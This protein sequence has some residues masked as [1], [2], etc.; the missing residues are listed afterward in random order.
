MP[1]INRPFRVIVAFLVL[2]IIGIALIPRLSVNFTPTYVK[3]AIT[4]T[5]SLPNSSP[6]IVERLA[7][8]PLENALSQLEGTNKVTS[9]SKYNGGSIEISFDKGV[10]VDF[11]KFEV[12]TII[13]NIYRKLPENMSYPRI[14]QRGGENQ[15]E[16]ERAILSYSINGPY[17]SYKLQ[18]DVEEFVKKPLSQLRDLKQVDVTD[19]NSLQ[20]TID[21]DVPTLIRYNL[22]KAQIT[23]ALNSMNDAVYAG[24]AAMSNGQQYFLKT[25]GQI[26]DMQALESI[27]IAIIEGKAIALKDVARLYLEEQKPNS[28]RRI[29]GRNAVYLSIYAREGV[30]KVLLAAEVKETINQLEDGLPEGVEIILEN[31]DTEFLA[32]E[33]NKIYIRTGLSVLILVVFIFL[34]NRNPKYLFTLFLGIIVNLCLTV[35]IVYALKVELHM[36]SIAGVT[37]SFG[38][39]VD[40]AIVM[41]D[42]MHRKKNAKIF[43]ALLAASL[44]TIMALLLVLLLPEDERR[45]LTD[46]SIVVAINL[47]VS[48]LI[49]LFFTPSLYT[50]LF[51][52]RLSMGRI[53]TYHRLRRKVRWFK[54]YMKSIAFVVKYRKAF[55][56]IVVLGFGL[57]V[58][59]LPVQWEGQEWYNKTIGSD[60]YQDEI[61]PVTDK[62][63]GG[64]LRKFVNEVYAGFRYGSPQQ[65]RLNVSARLP[66]GTTLDDANFV[67]SKVEEYLVGI[68]G[69]DK[70]ITN[71]SR[72]YATTQITFTDAYETS[73]LPYQLKGRLQARSIDLT[74]VAWSIT[75]VG[76]GFSAG[77]ERGETPS[78]R[79]KMK[80][81]NFDELERQA[82][83]MADKL[84]E[85]IRVNEVNT[86]AQVSWRSQ[87]TSEYVLDFDIDRLATAGINRGDILRMLSDLTEPMPGNSS[88]AANYNNE[89]L[90]VYIKASNAEAFSKYDL[91]EQSLPLDTGRF[92]K[93]KDYASLSFERTANEI[94]KEDRQYLRALTYDYNG[95]FKFA[96]RHRDEKIKEMNAEIPVGYVV[97]TQDNYFSFQREKRQYGILLVLIVG[98]FFICSIL[99]ENLKQPFNIIV[100]IPISFIGLFLI[101]SLFDFP[102]DNGGYAAFIL[103]GGL[104]VNASIFIVNDFN[105]SRLKN[106]NRAILKAVV[107]KAQ[108]ILLTILS[109]C[110]GLI[111]FL[112]EGENEVFWFSLAIGTIG[113]LIFSII[114]VFV[115]LPVFLSRKKSK[116]SVSE[117]LVPEIA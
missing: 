32:K 51:K 57:P 56:V 95:S 66:F 85:H 75:G 24:M 46:F 72:G 94:H 5:Y 38:L 80:G 69:V 97:E 44:T 93:I 7:T 112:L 105:N 12:S 63:L 83:L 64:A 22:T 92:I 3:P 29:N 20:I 18:Q 77:G 59:K 28:Y 67:I 19:G 49:A 21:F 110:F 100:T 40:N 101:F 96:Q 114:A 86:N 25:S 17:A 43:L 60:K 82:E 61:R 108:P 26:P 68:E 98:I 6:D 41:L 99:F 2:A 45:D 10:D 35:I 48:L 31:D 1:F 9:V 14:E 87:N 15:N 13:R 104:V 65:T 88:A 52:E 8:S 71:V 117:E 107:G 109:T 58:F 111:P 37:I 4:I 50:L 79:V 11:R 30:N 81:Y 39:I 78:M 74:G 33:M 47:G 54:A 55:I 34:I 89:R 53:Q 70:F 16:A 62:V 76:Q 84:E 42:H 27:D 102:M 113:G 106:E 115:C 73:A 116:S 36:Y 23:T 90:P 91:T 103:L